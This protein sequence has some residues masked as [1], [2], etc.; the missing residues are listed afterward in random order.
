MQE[1]SL[2]IRWGI[3]A[4]A[5]AKNLNRENITHVLRDLSLFVTFSSVSG[6]FMFYLLLRNAKA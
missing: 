2:G 4:A 1:V 3:H 6:I 5:A